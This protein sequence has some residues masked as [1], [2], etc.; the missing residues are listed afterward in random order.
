[1]CLL[2]FKY[3][4]CYRNLE[5]DGGFEMDKTKFI[6]RI[7]DDGWNLPVEVIEAI[8]YHVVLAKKAALRKVLLEHRN[9]QGEWLTKA[10]ARHYQ[11]RALVYQITEHGQNC[12]E[13]RKLGKELQ[14]KYGVTELEAINILNGRNVSDYIAKYYRIKHMIPDYVDEHDIAEMIASNF[15]NGG[16]TFA[17]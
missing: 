7:E 16:D 17:I 9:H 12:G 10:S 8:E 2:F 14:K 13:L 11:E 15:A 3:A 5:K 6:V 1:M 4:L